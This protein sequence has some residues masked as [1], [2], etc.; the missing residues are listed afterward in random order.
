[1][2]RPLG[3]R[4]PDKRGAAYESIFGRPSATHHQQFQPSN[5]NYAPSLPPQ[6]SG[7]MFY[8]QPQQYPQNA[9]RRT[10]YAPS[11]APSNLSQTAYHQQQ[12]SPS[13][14]RQSYPNNPPA[15]GQ[16]PPSSYTNGGSLA[17]PAASIRARSLSS[18]PGAL[19]IIAPQPEEPPDP[20]LEALTQSGLT[21]AQ[22]Y[23]KQVYMN[24]PSGSQ[25][26]FNRFQSSPAPPSSYPYQNGGPSRIPDAPQLVVP[27]EGE[28][29]LGIEFTGDNTSDH[30]DNDSSEL[31]WARKDS[32]EC[33]SGP[34]I[35]VVQ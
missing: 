32:R 18:H 6:Q 34:T 2:D 8:Y 10:S 33:P 28:G 29:R 27:L 19:G 17:P 30:E 20:T 24:N 25:G 4:Q 35:S 22:A 1:M 13:I 26:E 11:F 16:P 3:P 31:P 7:Q 5:L 15:Y 21:P 12:N 23:Q 14:Y 9:D